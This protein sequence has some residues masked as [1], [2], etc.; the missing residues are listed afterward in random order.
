[1]KLKNFTLVLVLL[2]YLFAVESICQQSPQQNNEDFSK[3]QKNGKYIHFNQIAGNFG[4]L[5]NGTKWTV[6]LKSLHTLYLT[7]FYDLDGIIPDFYATLEEKTL[8]VLPSNSNRMKAGVRLIL[9]GKKN[10]FYKNWGADLTLFYSYAFDKES[11]D[12]I[13]FTTMPTKQLTDINMLNHNSGYG[14]D[15]NF[16]TEPFFINAYVSATTKKDFT[17]PLLTQ[18]LDKT[19]DIAYYSFVD[20]SISNAFFSRIGKY[21][22]LK[23]EAGVSGYDVFYAHYDKSTKLISSGKT[24]NVLVLPFIELNYFMETEKEEN[25][26]FGGS[27]KYFDGHIKGKVWL[28]VL[29]LDVFGSAKTGK[30]LIWRIGTEFVSNR[31]FENERLWESQEKSSFMVNLVDLRLGF[32]LK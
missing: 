17:K 26:I 27:L 29:R 6:G 23:F 31:L 10:K 14:I 15:L 30:D 16:F 25:Y 32:S 9:P 12:N 5:D 8:N 13:N 7:T 1:M 21:H 11:I 22:L 3:L 2:V 20:Y 18:E 28:Q 4:Y 19:K 24:S